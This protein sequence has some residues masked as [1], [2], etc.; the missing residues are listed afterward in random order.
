MLQKILNLF[1]GNAPS[2]SPVKKIS[3]HEFVEL[4]KTQKGI[5][6]DVRTQ[7]EYDGGH[8]KNAQKADVM[9]GE[10]ARKMHHFDATKVYYLYC[11]SGNRSARAAK[12]LAQ[13][14]FEKVYNIGG[15]DALKNAGFTIR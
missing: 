14:G 8:L 5:I 10:F 15:F 2:G 12:M 11:R 7:S 9:S 4:Y 13:K 6:L 3:A 1:K